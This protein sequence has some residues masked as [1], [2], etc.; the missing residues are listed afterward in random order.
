MYNLSK[1]QRIILILFKEFLENYNSRNL[2]KII[3]ISHVGTFKILKKL[4]KRGLLN[5]KTIGKAIIYSLKMEN[6]VVLKEIELAL[7][8]ESQLHN[9]WVEEFKEI[10]DKAKLGILF[11][12]ILKNEK[13]A[14]DID[15]LIISD[16]KMFN[17]IKKLVE[18]KNKVLTKKIHLILQ[19]TK[20]F[21]N[22]ISKKNKTMLKII[23][24]GIILF[25]YTKL[26]K[27]MEDII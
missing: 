1:E 9:K 15:L 8:L 17:K 26:T 21:K 27:I 10:K 19:T 13:L 14:K 2:S 24:N 11:G 3:G 18:I 6:P 20:D 16:K 22:D 4:E 5:S 25:G 7:A 12:S 23:K